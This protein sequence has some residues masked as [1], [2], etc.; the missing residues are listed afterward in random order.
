MVIVEGTLERTRGFRYNKPTAKAAS[1]LK[2]CWEILHMLTS[3][4]PYSDLF[5]IPHIGLI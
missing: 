2:G 1:W 3:F 5:P 4:V